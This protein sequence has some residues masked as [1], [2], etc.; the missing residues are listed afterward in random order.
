MKQSFKVLGSN[1]QLIRY[2]LM[3]ALVSLVISV[4]FF[5]V[6]YLGQ[7]S[8]IYIATDVFGDEEIYLKGPGYLVA[9][10][11]YL[12]NFFITFVFSAGL[13]AHVL[14]IFRGRSGNFAHYM[15]LAW[16]KKIPILVLSLI[17][18]TVGLIL[19]AIEQR[20]RWLGL[21]VSR[22]LGA[23]WALATMFSLPIVVEGENNAP[24]AIKQSSHLFLSR[25]G[26]NIAARIS[27][28]GL[29]LLFYLLIVI[30]FLGVMVVLLS[31]LGVAGIVA[32]LVLFLLSIILLSV[33]E[34]A[35]SS[36][37]TTALYYYAR[38]AQIPAAFDPELLNSVLI[39][40]TPKTGLFSKK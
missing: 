27:F 37:L 13:T 10:L 12:T 5:G 2:P 11:W 16:S 31:P 6:F 22:L 36:V 39:P 1:K 26:E 34:S 23:I 25:W 14:D 18:A 3:G 35:A 29:L 30:P 32:V 17:F 21:I 19:R 20:A 33:V 4:V 9:F 8:M 28:A 15:K 40:K 38:Y 7:D 24:R